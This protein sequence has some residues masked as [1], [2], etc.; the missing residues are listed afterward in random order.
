MRAVGEKSKVILQKRR[1]S[2]A[3]K[4]L[5]VWSLRERGSTKKGSGGCRRAGGKVAFEKRTFAGRRAGKER[6]ASSSKK[7]Q[8]NATSREGK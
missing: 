8:R 5:W 2:W 3:E 6:G 7:L 1:R 4:T